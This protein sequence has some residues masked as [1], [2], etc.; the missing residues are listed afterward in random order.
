[1]NARASKGF[2]GADT[3]KTDSVHVLKKDSVSKR[4]F[5]KI[6]F[7]V[8]PGIG[9]NAGRKRGQVM[10]GDMTDVS[11]TTYTIRSVKYEN[12]GFNLDAGILFTVYSGSRIN[13]LAGVA[14]DNLSYSG[15]AMGTSY[16][17]RKNV[18]TDTATTFWDYTYQDFFVEIPVSVSFRLSEIG[19]NYCGF[20]IGITGMA[21][22]NETCSGVRI[23]NF[24]QSGCK[25]ALATIGLQYVRNSKKHGEGSLS[26]EP[27]YEYMLSP[28]PD[29]RVFWMAG[30]KVGLAFGF[31]KK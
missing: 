30:L 10:Q 12:S 13:V 21:L 2:A 4:L 28:F 24:N 7:Y 15:H 14:V 6:I 27:E 1:M 5:P 19:H 22:V 20:D 11:S 23:D 31:E 26:L 25:G 18:L 16:I 29:H 17:S 9:G 3:P 8:A